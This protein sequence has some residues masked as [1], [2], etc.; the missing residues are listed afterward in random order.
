MDP[1]QSPPA[2]PAPTSTQAEAA[3]DPASRRVS[4]RWPLIS[5]AIAVVLAFLLGAL[6]LTRGNG[7]PIEADAEWMEEIL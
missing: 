2:Q 4:R 7:R 3:A 6:S 5:G 1:S